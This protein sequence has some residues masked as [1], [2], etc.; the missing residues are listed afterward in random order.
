MSLLSRLSIL[1]LLSMSS[2]SAMDRAPSKSAH[3]VNWEYWKH[4]LLTDTQSA[5]SLAQETYQKAIKSVKHE[6][7]DSLCT[8]F[9]SALQSTCPF[10]SMFDIG[11]PKAFTDRSLGH[12]DRFEETVFKAA[13]SVF[14]TNSNIPLLYLGFAAGRLFSDFVV[15]V[16][17]L[18]DY[19][20][21]TIRFIAIDHVYADQGVVDS[22]NN[23]IMICIANMFPQ[24]HFSVDFI[25]NTR[26]SS[27]QLAELFET[28]V[29]IVTASGLTDFDY[30]FGLLEELFLKQTYYPMNL[31]LSGY[32]DMGWIGAISVVMGS[33]GCPVIFRTQ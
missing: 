8:F 2:M 22:L 16:K 31:L 11:K 5:Q 23:Q 21:A 27:T 29:H 32:K 17:L 14:K 26:L 12:R 30:Y 28:E 1:L 7:D 10:F 6:V 25:D 13:S 18:N 19:P 24:A 20:E 9:Y 15:L 3:G 33:N 4:V